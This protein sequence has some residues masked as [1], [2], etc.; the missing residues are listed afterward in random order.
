[1]PSRCPCGGHAM[2]PPAPF[3]EPSP[4]C[5]EARLVQWSRF[6]QYGKCQITDMLGRVVGGCGTLWWFDGTQWAEVNPDDAEWLE[7]LV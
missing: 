4:C 7:R 3:G 6:M 1:M 2:R 5:R